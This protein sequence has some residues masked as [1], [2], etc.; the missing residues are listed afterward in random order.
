L[1]WRGPCDPSERDGDAKR[2]IFAVDSPTS[3][4]QRLNENNYWRE[5]M[6][7]R[8]SPSQWVVILWLVMIILVSC[9]LPSGGGA[10]PMVWIDRP[11]DGTIVPLAPLILQAHAVDANGIAKIEF[12]VSD[13]LISGVSTGGARMEEASIEWTP[14]APGVYTLNVRAMDTQGNTNAHTPVSVQITVSGDT[15]TSTPA[16]ASGQCAAETLAAPLLLSP[17]DGA[18]V[19]GEPLLT[20]SYPDTSCHP[21]S[22]AVDISSDTSFTDISLGFG[23]LDHNETSRQWPLPAG[24][25]YYWRVKAYVPDVNGPPSPAWSFCIN[26]L[27]TAT[28]SVATIT[29]LKNANCRQGPGTAYDS[30]DAL[31]QGTSVA[32]EGRN[33]DSSW[34]WVLKP[35]GSGRC[36]IS[37]S[38]GA[39]SGNWQVVRVITA[40]PPPATVA[41]TSAPQDLTPPEISDLST[42]PTIISVQTQCGA[43]PPTTVVRAR[44]ADDGG[45]ARVIARVSGVGEFDMASAGDGYY[46][47]T[48]GPFGEAG[49][50]SIFVR[51]QDNA[52]TTATSTPIEVQVVAC[53]G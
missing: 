20:W 38:V 24:Q 22:Y 40:P 29:L 19:T 6:S 14:P 50:L 32:I 5:S 7:N 48:L 51:A 35:S 46:Q 17:V 15:S 47:V 4:I 44:V 45:I 37:A 9:T 3:T 21:Y 23:T 2:D 39:A 41:S 28:P 31:L 12:L 49:T 36:W 11:L 27:T 10:G 16:P 30:V 25:C 18:A 13:S 33:E 42:N 8:F 53:P 26:D 43:T 34:F 1:G 52:G